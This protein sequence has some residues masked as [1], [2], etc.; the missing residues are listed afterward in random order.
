VAGQFSQQNSALVDDAS[1]AESLTEQTKQLTGALAVF[2]LEATP[3]A[4]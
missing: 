4:D 3:G 1:A 2:K